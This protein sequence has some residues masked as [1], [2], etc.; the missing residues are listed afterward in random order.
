MLKYLADVKIYR[1][2][3]N[4][5]YF[6]YCGF[7]PLTRS[8]APWKLLRALYTIKTPDIGSRS[9]R[10]VWPHAITE[11]VPLPLFMINKPRMMVAHLGRYIGG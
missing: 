8:F 10:V 7:R 4:K 9:A 11:H 6:N 3:F 1:T 2:T 5:N